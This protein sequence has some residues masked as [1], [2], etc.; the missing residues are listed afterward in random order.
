MMLS[1]KLYDDGEGRLLAFTDKHPP[2]IYIYIILV[3]T[4]FNLPFLL[5]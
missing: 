5:H 3:R 1:A 4:S 2:P